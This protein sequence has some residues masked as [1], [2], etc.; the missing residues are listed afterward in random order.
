MA[1]IDV[2]KYS[3]DKKTNETVAHNKSSGCKSLL[4]MYMKSM[5]Y[6]D[7]FQL[8]C[9]RIPRARIVFSVIFQKMR[10]TS[11]FGTAYER[12]SISTKVEANVELEDSSVNSRIRERE[13]G[14]SDSGGQFA[15][16]TV[17][18]IPLH[19]GI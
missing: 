14:I 15:Q 10:N 5:G 17:S 7:V 16:K 13:G 3:I 4:S 6:A 18:P 1:E 11:L 8:S 19:T 9:S 12:A 2:G